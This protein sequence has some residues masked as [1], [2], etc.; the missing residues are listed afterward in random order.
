MYDYGARSYD[1]A[2]AR[3][4][5][6]DPLAEK[7][8]SLTS[9][10]YTDNNPI[11]FID[12]DGRSF[13][14]SK[15]LNQNGG[16]WTDRMDG[17]L[18][19]SDRADADHEADKQGKK[20][21]SFVDESL[22]NENLISSGLDLNSNVGYKISE[23]IIKGISE[24]SFDFTDFKSMNWRQAIVTNLELEVSNYDPSIS[25]KIY[26]RIEFSITVGVP[27]T[28][29]TG[30]NR[31]FVNPNAARRAA[32][33]AENVAAFDVGYRSISDLRKYWFSPHAHIVNVKIPRAFAQ[34]MEQEMRVSGGWFD[35]DPIPGS[36]VQVGEHPI[37]PSVIPKKAI[38]TKPWF[39]KQ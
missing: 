36:R 32:R 37:S 16:H 30:K 8:Q 12:P 35:V 10:G 20:I 2:A 17:Y 24:E 22:A 26:S 29:G 13:F 19:A 31:K 21:Q 25:K 3:W 27:I 18:S 23:S 28:T 15:F 7:Y 39:I 38:F 33:V 11:K 4:W 9:Y 1:A 6:V 34:K 5:V 14:K